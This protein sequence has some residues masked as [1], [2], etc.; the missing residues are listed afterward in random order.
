M[1]QVC[2]I[3]RMTKDAQ[4]SEYGKGKDAGLV[5][6]FTLA[7]D[8][9]S[10]DDTADFIS[11]VAFGKTAELIDFYLSKGSKIGVSGSIQT[12][13][14]EDKEGNTHYTTDVIVTRLDFCD[15]KKKSEED[16]EEEEEKPKKKYKR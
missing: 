16:E 15:S 9:A 7:V 2:L 11:C 1:N 14:Y 13:R 12:G 4:V 10:K 5:A 3:G 6:R 8:R